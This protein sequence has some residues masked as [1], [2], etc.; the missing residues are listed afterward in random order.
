MQQQYT[1]DLK[2]FVVYARGHHGGCGVG[3]DRV[4]VI[5]NEPRYNQSNEIPVKF[6]A[7]LGTTNGIS[8]S[9]LRGYLTQER[10]EAGA[11]YYGRKYGV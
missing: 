5:A 3:N 4:Y 10:A 7:H 11:K 6:P 8:T 2:F 9:V 1:E